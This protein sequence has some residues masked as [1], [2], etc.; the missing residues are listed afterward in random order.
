MIANDEFFSDERQL[1][2]AFLW[3]AEIDICFIAWRSFVV[4]PAQTHAD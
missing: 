1:P 4:V 3:G 2:L